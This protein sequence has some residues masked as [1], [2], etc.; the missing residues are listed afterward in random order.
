MVRLWLV[1]PE[2][3]KTASSHACTEK[4]IPKNKVQ[5]CLTTEIASPWL[6]LEVKAFTDTVAVL[7]CLLK[8]EPKLLNYLRSS[9]KLE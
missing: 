3:N 9:H 2:T 8:P 5:M 1:L 4:E 6:K 7:S